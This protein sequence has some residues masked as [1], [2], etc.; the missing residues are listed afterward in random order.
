VSG[1]RADRPVG[2]EPWRWT[3]RLRGSR[4]GDGGQPMHEAHKGR[5]AA[6]TDKG[7]ALN[8]GWPGPGYRRRQQSASRGVAIDEAQRSDGVDTLRTKRVCLGSIA[9]GRGGS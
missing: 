4:V 2:V 1:H 9:M 6:M 8:E 5:C 7:T 3:L